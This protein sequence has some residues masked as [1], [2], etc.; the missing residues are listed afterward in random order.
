[1]LFWVYVELVTYQQIIQRIVC[2]ARV[3]SGS[4][5]CV[6]IGHKFAVVGFDAIILVLFNYFNFHTLCKNTN[7]SKEIPLNFYPQKIQLRNIYLVKNYS[8]KNF[9][10]Q[11]F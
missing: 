9:P 6:V 5:F 8:A 10:L 1:M 11:Q 3:K 2:G 4:T 7:K